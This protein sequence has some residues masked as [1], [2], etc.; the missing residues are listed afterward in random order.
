MQYT[1]WRE[2]YANKDVHKVELKSDPFR[3]CLAQAFGWIP[4]W[5]IFSR[6]QIE[7]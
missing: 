5:E 3:V 1:I 4:T 7:G 6:Y 2:G